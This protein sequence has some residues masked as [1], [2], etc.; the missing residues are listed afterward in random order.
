M[1]RYNP[2]AVVGMSGRFPNADDLSDFWELLSTG[3]DSITE[4]GSSRWKHEDYYHP[5]RSV[6]GKTNQKHAAFLK[7]INKFDPLFFNISPAEAIEMNPSQKLMMELAWSVIENS[8]L[9]VNDIKGTLTGVYI[10][11][12]W[13][14]FEHQRKH[15]NAVITSH[16]AIGQ[17][18]NAIA[19]RIS[20]YLGLRGPS[21]VLDTGCS[22]SLVALHM[23]CQAL[24]DGTIEVGLAGAV[25]HLLDP[26]QYIL[27]SKFGGLS[28]KGKCST[29]DANADGF[30]RGE[31][32]AMLMLKRLEDA[33]KNGDNIYAVIKGSAINNNGFNVNLPATSV[34][35]QKE[36]LTQAYA[37][38][39]IQPKDV[40][41]VEAHGTGTKL[42]DPTE[43]RALG[44][45]FGQERD[46]TQKLRVGSVKTNIGHLEG[47]AGMAGLIKVVLAMKNKTLPKNLNFNEPNPAIDFEVLNLE[48][49]AEQTDWPSKNDETLKAGI[50]SFGW[51][52]T[53]AHVVVEEYRAKKA[54]SYNENPETPIQYFLPLSARSESALK[55]Y[56]DKYI[57][58]LQELEV[59]SD[60]KEVCKDTSITK[61]DFEYRKLFSAESHHH[62]VSQLKEFQASEESVKPL[63]HIK[64]GKTVFIFPGQGSQWVA[65]GKT[66]YEKEAT[67]RNALNMCDK[68]FFQ[69][70]SWSLIDKLYHSRDELKEIDIVQPTL[71]AVQIAL[72][73]LWKSWGIIPDTVVGHSMGEIAAA[74]IS[75]SLSLH[76]AANIIC[77]RSRL[78]K[79]VSGQGAMAVT[80]LSVDEA[81]ALLK[82]YPTLSI[83]VNN[84]PKSTVLAGD[85]PSIRA[86]VVELEEKNIFAKQV[87]VNVASHSHQMDPL[88]EDL[89][90]AV[91][92][93]WPLNNKI[94]IYSTVLAQKVDSKTFTPDY[95]LKNLRET[96]QFASV[97]D[98]LLEDD[99]KIFIEVS[100]HPVLVTSINECL[101]A[102]KVKN[103]VVCHSLH[104]D[105]PVLQEALNNFNQLYDKGK[106][107]V[108]SRYY[109]TDQR[110][111]LD[112][113]GYPFQKETYEIK[114]G[115]ATSNITL[116][117]NRHPWL[118][119][120]VM[121]GGL[122]KIH[123]WDKQIDLEQF[124]MLTNKSIGGKTVLPSSFYI[125]MILAALKNLQPEMHHTLRRLSFKHLV[126]T[127]ENRNVR[128]QI[129]VTEDSS[130]EGKLECFYTN[131][132]TE[133]KNEWIQILTGEYYC[134]NV[135]DH[136]KSDFPEVEELEWKEVISKG[137][138]Y[139][140][141]EQKGI[142][143]GPYLQGI[144]ELKLNGNQI[145]ARLSL[146]PENSANTYDFNVDPSLLESCVQT[147][148]AKILTDPKINADM[149][150]AITSIGTLLV[151]EQI[152]PSKNFWIYANSS[153][154]TSEN[155]HE[156]VIDADLVLFDEDGKAVLLIQQLSG[157]VRFPIL[158]AEKDKLYHKT[159]W[160]ESEG[161][162]GKSLSHQNDAKTWLLFLNHDKKSQHIEK[163]LTI[164]GFSPISVYH[165]QSFHKKGNS[166]YQI[167][168]NEPEHYVLLI[169]NVLEQTGG[170]LDGIFY[171][172]DKFEDNDLHLTKFDNY[173][174][175]NISSILNAVETKTH[176]IVGFEICIVTENAQSLGNPMNLASAPLLG[177]TRVLANEY[178]D[179]HVRV[180]DV[181]RDFEA[182]DIQGL[183]NE[184]LQGNRNEREISIR[185][186]K[187]H[188]ARLARYNPTVTRL[189]NAQFSSKG[190]YLISELDRT[191]I[192]FVKWM[193]SRGA[194]KFLLV[195]NDWSSEEFVAQVEELKNTGAELSI[196]NINIANY[197]ELLNVVNQIE[198][199]SPLLGVVHH[200]KPMA[201]HPLSSPIH[202][203][204]I[205]DKIQSS[206]N[207]HK[208]TTKIPVEDF[209]L[210]SSAVAKIGSSGHG[211]SAA[212][213][214]FMDQL[215]ALRKI[216]D[217]PV[218]SIN[219]AAFSHIFT[220]KFSTRKSGKNE[221]II[222]NK[223]VLLRAYESVSNSERFQLGIFNIDA[224]EIVETYPYL[225]ESNYFEYI[226]EQQNEVA[227]DTDIPTVV[228]MLPTLEDKK[229]HI[230]KHLI[231]SVASIIK[232]DV[233]KI[234]VNMTFKGLGVDSIMAVQLRN[235]LEKTLS[236]KLSITDF[237][238]NPTISLYAEF[239]LGK[240]VNG[241]K[242]NIIEQKSSPFVIPK[243]NNKAARRLFCFHDAGGNS[244]LYNSW[245][246]HIS[247]ETELV[248]FELPGRGHRSSIDTYQTIEE[249]AEDFILAIED[250]TDKPFSF[251]GHS[252][253]GLLAYTAAMELKRS[254]KV[255]P[256][257]LFISSMPHLSVYNKDSLDHKMSESELIKLF[258]HMS[259]E[260]IQDVELRALLIKNLRSDLA[261][262]SS[263]K[264]EDPIPLSV[265]VVALRG[266]DDDRVSKTDMLAWQ[267]EFIDDFQ[268]IERKGGHYFIYDDTEY[269]TTL[270]NITMD[271]Y[272]AETVK[273]HK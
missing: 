215:S 140:K 123:Y 111:K 139:A 41:Y 151:L 23:A 261:L 173:H 104:K 135:E 17:S 94:D 258:P 47:A 247:P 227:Q 12:I 202:S 165:G 33:E 188:Y 159:T 82:R 209:I 56:I 239:V 48:V 80:E 101:D 158:N 195:K 64:N 266:T 189:Q 171:G 186:G 103:A 148:F 4:I 8:K 269:V 121:L 39:G 183:L 206:W 130:T 108:W 9:P 169:Q 143:Y 126:S 116:A 100:P 240:Y 26:D 78:M 155:Q 145:L 70:T 147:V 163:Q 59:E 57:H 31:G 72:G 90:E 180:I 194:R 273:I 129:K 213:Y 191:S 248:I 217:L 46:K 16:S 86:M 161:V 146:N 20:Y 225:A 272:M 96:V 179:C 144:D 250:M 256:N 24:Q 60:F 231:R 92:R 51:G 54:T 138:F 71:C 199:D 236:L 53:N 42:G 264:Y 107:I 162:M 40:H 14:D 181:L 137:E 230:E 43:C 22:S 6:Q 131:Q 117:N 200:I 2:I 178:P 15:K 184:I 27:L 150:T 214:T 95:W 243:P 34:T 21:L 25:N 134:I 30:V 73:E 263:F 201:T 212:C 267:K 167:N 205:N 63:E 164:K 149:V 3:N 249:F 93:I 259:E 106:S 28:S 166:K 84:S 99:H 242:K 125:E 260:K 153:I 35:G 66:L 52:G 38:S 124:S 198:S 102:N 232:A 19:N 190:Y 220:P 262:L 58:Y 77:A 211:S 224:K 168:L 257:E 141:L 271:R 65:M 55:E 79:T 177:Y 69:Y 255:E 50:N 182:D 238:E 88:K 7:G 251:F 76:D 36:V 87:R 152:D 229:H 10:G 235:E 98:K 89:Y 204:I 44:E 118:G 127:N 270:V 61:P 1:K 13:S 175:R 110:S 119:E 216:Q 176:S 265:P 154:R 45:F 222:Q 253:G 142:K 218:T 18:S 196:K 85:E 170:N 172:L 234:G 105:R 132:T 252:L 133:Y 75:G 197:H 268:L 219:W 5:D 74:Y 114:Q 157:K 156:G 237:W 226:R 136:H 233:S 246:E 49:Q 193:F 115:S 122:Q 244:T 160:I 228:N 68:V 203:N 207:L 192:H 112:L 67:F 223:K 128:F 208:I 120:K 185:N 254:N 221:L 187:H 91:A 29:F 113:P 62:L 11:N 109:K 174:Y 83:A 81:E 245:E 32:G 210:L 37:Y 241:F 97:M